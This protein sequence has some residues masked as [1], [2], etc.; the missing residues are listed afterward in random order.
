MDTMTVTL[1]LPTVTEAEPVSVS[2]PI[3]VAVAVH[4]MVSS[5]ELVELERVMALPVPR[6]VPSVIF[7]HA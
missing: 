1:V 5:G 4:M 2:P 6:L 3:S 7:V